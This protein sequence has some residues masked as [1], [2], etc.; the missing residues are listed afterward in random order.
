MRIPQDLDGVVRD[1]IRRTLIE[2]LQ[3]LTAESRRADPRP[4]RESG[5][6]PRVRGALWSIVTS[7]LCAGI[8]LGD[9]ALG[10]AFGVRDCRVAARDAMSW[11]Q[12]LRPWSGEEEA[13]I[14]GAAARRRGSAFAWIARRR[15]MAKRPTTSMAGY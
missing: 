1:E 13:S 15:P 9:R 7:I 5:A 12:A 8:P 14:G 6:A 4:C 10:I 2:E 3:M 11:R